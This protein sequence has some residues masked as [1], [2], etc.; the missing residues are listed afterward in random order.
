[1]PGDNA[2]SGG[3]LQ[4]LSAQPEMPEIDLC[5]P[6]RSEGSLLN[7][8]DPSASGRQRVIFGISG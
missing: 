8:K 2:G 1:M 3:R 4:A 7:R 5:H 6:K